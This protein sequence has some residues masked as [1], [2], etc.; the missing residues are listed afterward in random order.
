MMRVVQ[1]SSD[2]LRLSNADSFW[3]WGFVTTIAVVILV[4]IFI[5]AKVI[6]PACWSAVALGI[7][8]LFL[9]IRELPRNFDTEF[10][11]D[12]SDNQLKVIKHPWLGSPQQD[13]YPLSDITNVRVVARKTP[14]P[15]RGYY[16]G[17]EDD[18][19]AEA[20]SSITNTAYNIELSLRSGK[21]LV[22]VWGGENKG[23]TKLAKLISE[24]LGLTRIPSP[25]L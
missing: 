20:K 10:W 6:R 14:K 25:R 17:Y 3:K 4:G 8:L 22:V 19:D 15:Y 23:A 13:D 2:H 9:L 5:A 24:F 1:K 11:F 7:F 16:P 21:T 18:R 12:R